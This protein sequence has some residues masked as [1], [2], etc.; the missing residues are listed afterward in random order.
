MEDKDATRNDETNPDA[1]AAAGG[2]SLL[3]GLKEEFR[4]TVRDFQ[5]KGALAIVKDAALDAK[6]LAVSAG[7]TAARL[8]VS[9][10]NT[11]FSGARTIAFGTAEPEVEV[12]QEPAAF[13]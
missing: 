3:D 5:E 2:G 4:G 8:S 9:A 7:T 11:A 13:P 12:E 10:G 6:D 1:G